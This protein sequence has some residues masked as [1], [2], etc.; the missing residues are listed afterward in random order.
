MTTIQPGDWVRLGHKDHPDFM[1]EGTARDYVGGVWV[2]P[3][4]IAADEGELFY[5]YNLLAH[6]PAQQLHHVAAAIGE[7][8]GN[9]QPGCRYVELAQAAMDAMEAGR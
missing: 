3:S 1:L 6:K 5:G 9:H 7:A 8:D 4:V 2:G